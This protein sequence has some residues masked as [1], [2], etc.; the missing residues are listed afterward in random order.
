MGAEPQS[1]ALGIIVTAAVLVMMPVLARL[2]LRAA[3]EL[4]SRAL[5]ADALRDPHMGRALSETLAGLAI[6]SAVGWTWA[7]PL[8]ALPL[9]PMIAREGFEAIGLRGA[10]D[11]QEY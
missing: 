6:N 8:A 7:D 10:D 11:N 2:K 3:R 5:R 9:V 4:N 1:I